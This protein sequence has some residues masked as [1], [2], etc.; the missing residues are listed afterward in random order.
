MPHVGTA[1]HSVQRASVFFDNSTR[2]LESGIKLTQAYT[3]PYAR[4]ALTQSRVRERGGEKE[5]GVRLGW[6][7]ARLMLACWANTSV[8][9]PGRI[10][11]HVAT[12]NLTE[13]CQSRCVMCDYWRTKTSNAIDEARA[14]SLVD[15]IRSLGV[16]T[17]RFLGGEPLL[18][19][20][21]FSV[22]E[23]TRRLGFDR[24]VLATNGLLLDRFADEINRSCVTNLTVSVDGIGDNNDRIRGIPG[25]FDR[26]LSNLRLIKRKRIKLATLVTSTLAQDINAL[27][28]LCRARG[29]LLDL[30]LPSFDLPY[31][32]SHRTHR[33]LA[34][35]WPSPDDVHAILE[36]MVGAGFL[37]ESLATGC[38]EY[39]VDRRYP[40]RHCVQG[41]F[42]LLIR[43]NGDVTLGCYEQHPVGNVLSETLPEIMA[44]MR[45]HE[46][47]KAM[48][49][50]ECGRCVCGW[51]ISHVF[52]HPISNVGYA[53]KRVATREAPVPTRSKRSSHMRPRAPDHDPVA[54]AD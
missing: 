8:P 24:I 42:A 19:K 2:Y 45:R 1:G 28:D 15:E 17:L 39:L 35:I 41:Y 16:G 49:Q 6:Y 47:A 4:P 52:R 43:A 53:L 12:L 38:H 18:R 54:A 26:V 13:N 40:I 33:N 23:H 44:S 30:N 11:P 51:A 25:H 32:D 21:L 50:L 36:A 46:E 27:I 20:D 48:F 3:I 7:E 37:T 5:D 9:L 10:R 22:L 31:T 14:R 29:Y 34:Q